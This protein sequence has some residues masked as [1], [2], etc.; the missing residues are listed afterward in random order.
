MTRPQP[1]HG[2]RRPAKQWFDAISTARQAHRETGRSIGAQFVEMALLWRRPNRVLPDEYFAFRLFDGRAW[3]CKREFIGRRAKP[4]VYGLNEPG[5]RALAEDKL[6]CSAQLAAFGLP[7]PRTVAI[8]GPGRVYPGAPNVDGLSELRA[9]LLSCNTYPLFVKPVMGTL[10]RDA[11]AFTGFDPSSNRLSLVNGQ[12]VDLHDFVEHTVAKNPAG[13]VFQELVRPHD[14]LRRICGPRLSTVRALVLNTPNRSIVHRVVWRVAVGDNMVD[15]FVHG[16]RG[17]L[18]AGIE[19]AT[20]RVLRVVSGTGLDARILDRHPD[21]GQSFDEVVLPDWQELLRVC[22][23]ASRVMSG[24]RVQGWDIALS[25]RG[26][27]L[28][29]V[30]SRS[31]FDLTQMAEGKGIADWQWMQFI[32]TLESAASS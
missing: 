21:T 32:E 25:D 26:P 1:A 2:K 20:G 9:F 31:D 27:L 3:A 5:W 18:I 6:V 22:Q 29:E 14:E 10:G 19:P 11:F 4:Y 30:N 15:N 8:T 24:I 28:M 7:V 13:M 12:F 23:T 16:R 17:N